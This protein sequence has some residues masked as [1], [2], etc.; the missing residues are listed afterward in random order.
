MDKVIINV[1]GDSIVRGFG[2][3]GK[4]F[5]DIESG[6][7]QFN[8]FGINGDTSRGVLNRIESFLNCDL[9]ILFYGLNDFLNGLPVAEVVSNTEKILEMAESNVLI[10]VPHAVDTED[11]WFLFNPEGINRKLESLGMEY[12][13]IDG[14]FKILNYYETLKDGE[15]FD[16]LHPNEKTHFDMQRILLD[17]L[18]VNYGFYK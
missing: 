6:H 5:I 11:L 2:V 3:E 13:A 10:C 15:L 18:E 17:F 7:L 1:V 14:D 4:S 12:K 9:L 16:G 8:N